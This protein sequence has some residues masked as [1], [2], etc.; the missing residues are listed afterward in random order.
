MK[1]PIIIIALIIL[2]AAGSVGTLYATGNLDR[3][4]DK[5]FNRSEV[6][7]MSDE[8]NFDEI[9][10][11]VKE[12]LNKVKSVRA[13]VKGSTQMKMGESD[14][15]DFSGIFG[16]GSKIDFVFPDRISVYNSETIDGEKIESRVIVIGENI[17]MKFPFPWL[18]GWIHG[19]DGQSM[20][21]PFSDADG[22]I[23]F[24]LSNYQKGWDFT[25]S[26]VERIE[27]YLGVEEINGVK[28]YHYKVK[29]KNEDSHPLKKGIIL[30]QV[31]DKIKYVEKDAGEEIL[32]SLPE[33][34]TI[35]PVSLSTEIG[36]EKIETRA[37]KGEIWIGK[38]D[39]LVY[40]ESYSSED[41]TLYY[42]INESG[43]AT[44]SLLSNVFKNDTEITYSDFNGDIKIE[45]PTKNVRTV[46]S[47]IK[48]INLLK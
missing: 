21:A 18:P 10:K 34:L 17:Y 37:A 5:I 25:K 41:A 29:I 43:E 20:P 30:E 16:G 35:F 15:V 4:I 47:I 45:A 39:F 36:E 48:K 12:N 9:L 28:C 27:E 2:I 46:D 32:I 38:N 7:D 44:L 42:D 22:S 19:K 11:R 26:D 33:W 8:K 31:G 13:E 40:K 23:D 3:I 1:K 24:N 6:L 14:P